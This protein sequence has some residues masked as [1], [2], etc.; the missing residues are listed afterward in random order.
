[1]LLFILGVLFTAIVSKKEIKQILRD[2]LLV[3]QWIPHTLS[4]VFPFYNLGEAM[5]EIDQVVNRAN[6]TCTFYFRDNQ[7]FTIIFISRLCVVEYL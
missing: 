2:P 4:V 6:E 1:M 5:S 3:D 7:F